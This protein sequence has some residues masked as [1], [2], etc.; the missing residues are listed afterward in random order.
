[1]IGNTYAMVIYNNNGKIN[2][3]L[4]GPSKEADM[5]ASAK[6]TEQLQKEFKDLFIGIGCCDGTFSLPVKA[7]RILYHV[8]PGCMTY[9]LKATQG[10]T[11]VIR[12]AEYNHTFRHG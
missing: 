5:R 8:L 1:M 10:R 3:V 11:R 7:D 2:Y 12:A 6:I 9:T 4:L